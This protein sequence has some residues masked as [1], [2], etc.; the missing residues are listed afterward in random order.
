VTDKLSVADDWL[1]WN[2][3]EC[4]VPGNRRVEVRC[5]DGYESCDQAD[6]FC[7]DKNGGYDWWAHK[8]PEGDR[9]DQYT[10]ADDIIAYRLARERGL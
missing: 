5:R 1:V 2:G 4:P 7:C 9:F 10:P 3:G 8:K 6:A